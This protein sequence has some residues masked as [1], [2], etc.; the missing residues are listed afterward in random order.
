MASGDP[1]LSGPGLVFIIHWVGM[2]PLY[3]IFAGF[4]EAMAWAGNGCRHQHNSESAITE[5]HGGQPLGAKVPCREG[6][7][8]S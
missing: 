8:A 2:N 3:G 5:A 1:I 7:G 6:Q 4:T